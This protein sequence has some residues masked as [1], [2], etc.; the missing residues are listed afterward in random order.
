[1]YIG[2]FV[3]GLVVGVLIGWGIVGTRGASDTTAMNTTGTSTSMA[4]TMTG[5]TTAGGVDLSGS[6]MGVT[7]LTVPS[8]QIAGIIVTVSH[9]DVSNPTWVVVYED[10][11]GVPGNALGAALFSPTSADAAMSGSVPLLRATV[12]GQTYLVGESV[13]NGDH[14]FS[15]TADKPVVDSSGKPVLTEFKTN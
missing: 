2:I 12:S 7:G 1:M 4:G 13:D 3:V 5:S 6:T 10:N 14:V 8:P 9:I 15:L 11:N